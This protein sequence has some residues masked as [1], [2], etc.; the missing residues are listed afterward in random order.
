M[1][2]QLLNKFYCQDDVKNLKHFNGHFKTN[3][4][5]NDHQTNTFSKF[6]FD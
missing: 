1:K 5:L 2:F 6:E 3:L 4:I